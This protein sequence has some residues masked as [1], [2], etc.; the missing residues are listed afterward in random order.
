MVD[1][2]WW[3]NARVTPWMHYQL[4]CLDRDLRNAFGVGLVANSGIRL[5]QEQLD[6]WY[7][8][9]TRTPNGRKVYDTRWWNGQLWYRISSAG[10][11]AQPG[12]SNHEIQGSKAAVD[13][14]DTGSDAGITNK[15]S[16]RGRWI[17]ANAWRYSLIASGDGFGEG[18]HFDITG[19]YNTP[20]GTPAGG[21]TVVPKEDDMT[22]AVKLNGRHLYT[23][24][25]EFIS[26][27][28]SVD[29][30]NIAKNVNS[31]Q[32]E[33]HALN[34]AQFLDYL[35]AMGIPRAVVDVNSGAVLNPQSGKLEGNGVWSRRREAVALEQ[36]NAA[37]LDEI[38]KLV[39][40][41]STTPATPAK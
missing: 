34:T 30:H 9:Y 38:L 27:N 31:A 18:W 35:D 11:V 7:A 32:D 3:G 23:M 1:F 20:P 28:G 19:I 6:I 33:Q 12:S 14:Q 37:K 10:T 26:H 39:K 16:V 40:P 5:A 22:V 29:Q 21:G 36:A 4:S 8:R 41:A 2:V 15:N 24:G 13:I 17:R 25:E